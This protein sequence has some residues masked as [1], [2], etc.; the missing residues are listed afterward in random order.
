M[1][2]GRRPD[3]LRHADPRSDESR[4]L[5][6]R[7]TS[8]AG[9]AGRAAASSQP[10]RGPEAGDSPT[11]AHGPVPA[12]A[13][14]AP[15]TSGG[16]VTS[17][18]EAAGLRRR[19]QHLEALEPERRRATDALWRG[20]ARLN[21]IV[22]HIPV[23]LWSADLSGV[24]KVVEGRGVSAICVAPHE[25][26]GR[27]LAELHP[28]P[29]SVRE[30]LRRAARGQSHESLMRTGTRIF[31]VYSSCLRNP[32]GEVVGIVGASTD[33]TELLRA[34][35]ELVRVNTA[36]SHKASELAAANAELGE[37]ASAVSHH[38]KAPLR[39]IHNYSDFLREDL[40][41]V[42]TGESLEY[43]D[44][45]GLA[46]RQAED[47]VDAMLE[48]AR[49]GAKE[50][51][52]ELVDVGKLL[53]S[54]LTSIGPLD[55][56]EV[57]MDDEWPVIRSEPTLLRQ[58]LQNL[59]TNAVKFNR[60]KPKRVELGVASSGVD[61]C[62]FFVRDNG[63]GIDAEHRDSVFRLFRRLHSGSEYEGTGVGLAIVRKLVIRLGGSVRVESAVGRGSTFFVKLPTTA[64]G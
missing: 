1:T 60:S 57:A 35:E 62:E 46:V 30:H 7:P 39:A 2:R 55:G 40:G 45:L 33:V 8:E 13:T 28:D 31:E 34:K 25:M 10:P 14:A 24:L 63:I 29:P 59:I 9:P 36:L 22:S 23:I 16:E 12:P 58:I 54:L 17:L 6:A 53:R 11:S 5:R 27:P 50:M 18:E 48:I 19:L 32:R 15:P 56:A 49:L 64:A 43:L 47:M 44:H 52:C 21:V 37:Y 51:D 42:A 26:V 41:G 61:H 20:V 4:P 38:V 3:A